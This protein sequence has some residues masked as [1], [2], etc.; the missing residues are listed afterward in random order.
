[1]LYKSKYTHKPHRRLA[2]EMLVSLTCMMFINCIC[3]IDHYILKAS[4]QHHLN[5]SAVVVG[6]DL[7]LFTW[8]LRY[9][10][11]LLLL[12]LKRKLRSFTHGQGWDGDYKVQS[13]FIKQITLSCNPLL[14]LTYE[15]LQIPLIL[16]FLLTVPSFWPL[17][18]LSHIFMACKSQFSCSAPFSL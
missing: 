2:R 1:M 5:S 16:H 9:R 8:T 6:F 17:K 18:T 3:K 12:F 13:L 7:R 15:L 11:V 10:S 4:Y 14:I